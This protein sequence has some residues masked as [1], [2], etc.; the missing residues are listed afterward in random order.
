[1][2]LA[3]QHLIHD[4]M[5]AEIASEPQRPGQAESAIRGAADLGGERQRVSRLVR[6][7]DTFD[8]TGL[9]SA[10]VRTNFSPSL[11][12]KDLNV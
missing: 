12:R 4:L 9:P 6:D 8:L 11:R 1:M 5:R 10:S 7:E 3:E 2:V